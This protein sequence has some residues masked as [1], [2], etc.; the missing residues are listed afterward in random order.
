MSS[1]IGNSKL[2]ARNTLLLYLRTFVVMLVSIFTSRVV[3]SNLGESDYGIYNIVGGFVSM[4]ALLSST[5]TV[6]SQRFISYELGKPDTESDLQK[7]FSVSVII[8]TL[9]AIFILVLLETFGIWFINNKINISPDR[10]QAAKIVFQCSVITFCVNLISIP[11]NAEIIA[12]ERMHVFAYISIIEVLL[13]LGAAYILSIFLGDKLVIY[14]II[15]LLI[16]FI[17][18][19]I[20][21]I[22]CKNNF[23]ECKVEIVKEKARYQEILSFCSWNILGSSS[24]ILNSQGIN[25]LI[26]L[27]FGVLL[28][29]A[30]GLAEQINSALNSFV[31]NFMTALNPQITKC[32]AAREY[33][34]MNELVI[35]GGKLA[36]C[37]LWIISF[38]VITHAESL[39]KLWL[40][41][42]PA[43]TSSF[44]KLALI[45]T[46]CQSLS[47]T[48]YTVMLASGNIKR[49]QLI[50]GSISLC[51]FPITYVFFK[52]GLPVEYGY[53]ST[54]IISIMCLIARLIILPSIIPM[55]NSFKYV[56]FVI[57]RALII[58][59]ATVLTYSFLSLIFIDTFSNILQF[60][61]AFGIAV[62]YSVILGLSRKEKKQIILSIQ[63]RL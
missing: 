15:M 27:F 32:F 41:E 7:T 8:H 10:I 28:N 30:R 60:I 52:C 44:V 1:N 34:Q 9:L 36:F 31:S 54:I 57:V 53:V 6:A 42:V 59:I 45:Y 62:F 13:K 48:L 14:A 22:Y 58:S 46:L 61:I 21:G 63:S 29:A 25:I 40:V 55:F 19:L 26:N 33:K 37:L 16:A 50:V 23:A 12:H 47:Q 39:L 49:Y 51:A 11:Y 2:V 4:F 24:V 56:R 18:R 5:L 35:F 3:L 17:L 20:Y 38:P 43:H